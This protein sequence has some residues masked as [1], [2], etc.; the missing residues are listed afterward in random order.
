MKKRNLTALTLALC[1]GLTLAGCSGKE[2]EPEETEP[3]EPAMQEIGDPSASLETELTNELGGA[4]TGLTVKK[5]EKA[6]YPANMMLTDQQ[7]TEDETVKFFYSPETTAQTTVAISDDPAA[8]DSETA[9]ASDAAAAV[10]P[11]TDAVGY[12]NMAGDAKEEL[13]IWDVTDDVVTFRLWWE[14]GPV[15]RDLMVSFNSGNA[16]T[17]AGVIGDDS[18]I[19]GTMTFTETAVTLDIEEC[20][21]EGLDL[22]DGPFVFDEKHAQSWEYADDYETPDAADETDVPAEEQAVETENTSDAYLLKVTMADGQVYEL[23][24]FAIE[25]MDA[26]TLCL[27]DEVAYLTYE[28]LANGAEINTKEQEETIKKEKETAQPVIDQITLIGTVSE[29][30]GSEIRAAREAYNAL[31]EGEKAYVTNEAALRWKELT[32]AGQTAEE[33][34][35][36]PEDTDEEEE[37]EYTDGDNW[38]IGY[39]QG[40]Q[41][42][43][44]SEAASYWNSIND[45]T[46][47]GKYNDQYEQDYWDGYYAGY[48]EY[49]ADQAQQERENEARRK[50]F[51]GRPDHYDEDGNDQWAG[52]DWWDDEDEAIDWD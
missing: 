31:T 30:S 2:E 47:N 26:V 45:P 7:I 40:I 39:E 46:A 8:A 27:E 12:W 18:M 35:P 36:E 37:E 22:G 3:E 25:D 1:L 50:A 29:D 14:N 33:E 51:E 19:S 6:A 4:V 43:S 16:G 24:S 48:A 28:S 49:E 42:K 9:D 11:D 44:E 41:G 34:E 5:P 20:T 52:E 32:L 15:T 21:Y 13:T 23:S 38:A 17:F 10:L